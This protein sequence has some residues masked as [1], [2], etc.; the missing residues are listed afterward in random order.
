MYVKSLA[1]CVAQSKCPVRLRAFSCLVIITKTCGD[2]LPVSDVDIMSSELGVGART[3]YHLRVPLAAEVGGTELS[4]SRG[5]QVAC[6]GEEPG[7]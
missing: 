4:I 1:Q 2:H 6:R 3:S 7:G 5:V